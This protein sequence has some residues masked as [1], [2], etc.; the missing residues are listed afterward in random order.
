MYACMCV[1]MYACM[2]VCVCMYVCVYY[3]Y[4]CVCM[5]VCMSLCVCMYVCVLCM[6]IN[7][8]IKVNSTV[9]YDITVISS[10]QSL[11]M[12]LTCRYE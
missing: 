11:R 5:Y 3:V 6:C 7:C 1:C 2:C 4:V 10:A 9:L 12:M 8:H